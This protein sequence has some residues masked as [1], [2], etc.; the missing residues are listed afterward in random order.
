MPARKWRVLGDDTLAPDTSRPGWEAT[1]LEVHLDHRGLHE[2]GG[3]SCMMHLQRASFARNS[4]TGLQALQRLSA[5]QRLNL[6][7][8]HE[9]DILLIFC[10][11]AALH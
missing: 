9:R 7:V 4:I 8:V 6:Q 2:I 1:V 11:Q 5:L 3:I 10:C